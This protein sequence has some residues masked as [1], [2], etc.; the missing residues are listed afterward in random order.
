M[1]IENDV[2]LRRVLTAGRV[3]AVVGL[4]ADSRRPSH[5]VARYMLANGYQ[6]VPVNPKENE[7]LGQRCYA[8]LADIPQSVD[9]VVCFRKSEYIP[10]IAEEAIAIGARTLWLQLGIHN[11]TAEQ[12][13]V[14]AGLDVVADHCFETEHARL[15]GALQPSG[16]PQQG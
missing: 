10:A 4:S 12:R 11:E 9:I 16:S 7:I 3:I 15:I 2:G 13:A 5:G 14:A 1:L 8:R 6:V